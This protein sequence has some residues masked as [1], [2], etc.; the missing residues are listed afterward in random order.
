MV[1]HAFD[2][3]T[4]ERRQADF[5]VWGQPG[6]QSEFQDSQDY[7]EKPCLV[8]TKT[9]QKKVGRTKTLLTKSIIHNIY[10]LDLEMVGEIVIETL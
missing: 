4:W 8:K 3:N 9:K 2:P 10:G 7:T 1:A 6:Q 5:W